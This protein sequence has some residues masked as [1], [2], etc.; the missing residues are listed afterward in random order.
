MNIPEYSLN[1]AKV[2]YFLLAILLIG[3]VFSFGTLE[4]KEDAP[5]V[6]KQVA[7]VTRYPGA[8]PNEVEL[9]IT[10][11]IE[12][13]IQSMR[14]IR[15]IKSESSYGLSKIDVELLATTPPD[16]IP[17]MWDEL[18]RKVMDVQSTLPQGASAISVADDFGDVFGIY[19]AITADQGFDYHDLR[20]WANFI[21]TELVTIEGVQ[22]ISL[23]GEQTEVVNV[24]ISASKLAN[25][26]IHLNTVAQTLKAQNVLV[27]T[28]EKVTGDLQMKVI[29]DGTYKSLDDIR[30]LLIASNTGQQVKFGDFARVEKGYNEPPA[31]LMRVD[32]KPAIG[33]GV[34]TARGEDVALTGKLVR[35]RIELLKPQIPL[36]IEIESLYPEDLIATEANQGFIINLIESIGI[37]IVIILLAMGMRA[38]FL[39]GSSLIFSIGGSLLI[40]ELMGTGLNRT[41]LAGFIIAMGMLVD[42]AIVVTDNAQIGIKRGLSRR[43]ALIDGASI[44]QWGLLGATLIAI[45]SFLPLYLAPSSVAE[46]VKPLFVVLAISLG[47]SW[48][49][50]LTQTTTFGNFMLKEGG[51]EAG[52]DPYDKPIYH[53]FEKLLKGLIRRK[54]VTIMAVI[55]MFIGSLVVMGLMPSNF[56]PN[57]DKPYFRVDIFFPDGYTIRNTEKNILKIEEYLMEQPDVKK[58]SVTIGQSP[59]RYYLASPSFGPKANYANVLIELNSDDSTKIY[60]ERLDTYLRN[61]FPNSWIRSTLFNLAPAVET[62]IEIGFIGENID[63]LERLTISAMQLMRD[64]P[65]VTDVRSSWGN[66]VPVWIPN[67]SQEKGQ[68]LGITRQSMASSIKLATNGL[69]MGEYRERDVFMPILLKEENIERFNLSNLNTLPVFNANGKTVPLEQVIVSSEVDFSYNTIKRYNRQRVMMA[70][71]VPVRGENTAAT[72]KKVFTAMEQIKI[73]EGYKMKVFGEAE[74]SAESNA[75]LAANMPLTFLLMFLV[76]L[77]LFRSYR[78]PVMI[79]LMVPLIFI[80]VVFGLVTTGKTLDFFAILGVLG[81]VGMNIKNAI[82]L[83]DQIGIEMKA[84]LA[85]LE[86][87]I[88][89]TKSRIIPVTMAS[90]TTILG[91]LPLLFDAMFGG[92]AASIMGGL[93]VATLLTI[94]V[95][96]VTYSLM[97]NISVS[98]K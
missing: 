55:A 66:K 98:K 2:I 40:M 19:Y 87:V 80:G 84:G 44:P 42:N 30:N 57:L 72:A 16:E 23:S 15:K 93:L 45:F 14:R 54:V 28:G 51:G 69:A 82:V 48:V 92:M 91:M 94:F 63:T 11:P 81:L 17:Q 95:L 3:G 4:K 77:F 24:F 18:R 60:E 5:F 78:K 86:A 41:S 6:I 22:K 58:V 90:G 73:P 31:N 38:G 1:N 8:T 59:L 39:I 49:L 61:N 26:G 25:L 65:G 21:K 71:C 53:K 12:R 62:P 67:Y 35:E 64:V 68:R 32:G 70:Q 83:V 89:A 97:F 9:L 56:I 29:A 43:K 79:M 36:G 52:K 27:N 20:K 75:A 47:L 37:V 88:Q 96:P 7:V 10:E 46:I 76:L 33:F 50:A 85:P 74:S 13:T 34:S